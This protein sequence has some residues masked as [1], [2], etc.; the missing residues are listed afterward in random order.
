MGKTSEREKKQ[1]T[2][3]EERGGRGSRWR[4]DAA[5]SAQSVRGGE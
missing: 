3:A 5:V 1:T 2:L 4:V